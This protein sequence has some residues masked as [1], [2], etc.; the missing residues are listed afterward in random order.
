MTV[1][2]ESHYRW[3]DCV[4]YIYEVIINFYCL[5]GFATMSTYC[6]SDIA[7][8]KNS[9]AFLLLLGLLFHCDIYQMPLSYKD[10]LYGTIYKTTRKLQ[11]SRYKLL[12]FLIFCDGK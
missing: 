5:H 4:P 1:Y 12:F 7:L 2:F 9:S 8:Q 11:F 6:V 10:I 3:A